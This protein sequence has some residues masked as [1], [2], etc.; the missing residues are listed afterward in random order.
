MRNRKQ[1]FSFVHKGIF[2][3]SLS[4]SNIVYHE[5]SKAHTI[6]LGSPFQSGIHVSSVAPHSPQRLLH[7]PSRSG[8]TSHPFCTSRPPGSQKERI[9]A[10]GKM[11]TEICRTIQDCSS[12]HRC[13]SQSLH[14]LD[15]FW[16][17]LSQQ[18]T[19]IKG[20]PFHE[21]G[22]C[23]RHCAGCWEYYSGSTCSCWKVRKSFF[24]I[25]STYVF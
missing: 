20:H 16:G 23:P 12:G 19:L 25:Q 15:P 14:H 1:V 10:A 8:F 3:F 9:L 5:L 4:W 24:L 2:L 18:Q 17:I 7:C 13:Q 6:L 11:F 21:R 22:L